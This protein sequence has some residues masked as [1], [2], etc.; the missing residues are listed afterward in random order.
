MKMAI[1]NESLPLGKYMGRQVDGSPMREA[2]RFQ[3]CQLC[4]GYVDVFDLVWTQDHERPVAATRARLNSVATA[5]T[6]SRHG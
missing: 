4:G 3:R 5:A 6:G 2:D 1:P